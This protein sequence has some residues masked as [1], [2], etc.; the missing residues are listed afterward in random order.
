MHF[1]FLVE[2]KSGEELLKIIVPKIICSEQ[3][4][5]DIHSYKGIGR[6]PKNLSSKDNASKTTLLSKLPGLLKG[7]ENSYKSYIDYSII[8]VCDLDKN[9][10]LYFLNELKSVAKQSVQ[11]SSKIFFCIAIEEMEAWL[12]GDIEAIR[13]SY[14]QAKLTILQSYENDSICDTWETLADAIY[15]GGAKALKLYK[16]YYSIG[17]I[18]IEWAKNIPSH[19]D[20]EQNISP[21]F[22]HFKNTIKQICLG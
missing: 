11:N 8:V 2:D 10:F 22:V 13:K 12:L 15:K 17:A 3:N 21:S 9:D 18:K 19:M 7:F 6:I 16:D 20:I 14:P 4:T 1:E 5:F